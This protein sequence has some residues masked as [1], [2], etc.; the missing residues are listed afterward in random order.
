VPG[1]D[2]LYQQDVLRTFLRN[3]PFGRDAGVIK[4][5]NRCLL[6]HRVQPKTIQVN[7]IAYSALVIGATVKI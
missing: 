2:K 6:Q 4:T 3:E 1:E 5:L 7:N